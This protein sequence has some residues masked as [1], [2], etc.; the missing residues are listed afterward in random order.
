MRENCHCHAHGLAS[1]VLGALIGAALGVMFAP[2]KGETTRRKLKRLAGDAYEEGR[3]GIM[4][5]AR[6]LKERVK[7]RAGELK[8]KAGHAKETLAERAGELK[9]RIGEKA[10]ELKHRAE[11]KTGELREKAADGLEKAAK[12][13]R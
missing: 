10:E 7:E 2:A 9:E 3:D 6:E 11:E 1:F 13:I 8:G 12:K 4:D 5:H